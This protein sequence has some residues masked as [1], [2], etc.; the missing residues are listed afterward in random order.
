MQSHPAATQCS[1]KFVAQLRRGRFHPQDLAEPAL[2]AHVIMILLLVH[3]LGSAPAVFP[4]AGGS[5]WDPHGVNRG[6]PRTDKGI[7]VD[8]VQFSH[9]AL[10]VSSY[11][12]LCHSMKCLAT[13]SFSQFRRWQ[14]RGESG[15][16]SGVACHWYYFLPA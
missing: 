3:S 13:A 10:T 12:M 15:S 4:A 7:Y 16:G 11:N 9:P 14:W 1:K 6:R 5:M 8:S 2:C